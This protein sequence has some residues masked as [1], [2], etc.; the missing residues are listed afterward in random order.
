MRVCGFGPGPVMVH[1]C[2]VSPGLC[3]AGHS[4]GCWDKEQVRLRDSETVQ[5]ETSDI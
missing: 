3:G 2:E 4:S 5:K 1:L